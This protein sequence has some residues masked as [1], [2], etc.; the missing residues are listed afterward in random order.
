[1]TKKCK[2]VQ[3]QLDRFLRSEL[4]L[5]IRKEIEDHLTTCRKC[6]EVLAFHQALDTNLNGKAGMPDD[7]RMRTEELLAT[8]SRRRSWL[9]QAFGEPIMKKIL[10][11]STAVAAALIAGI[12]LVPSLAQGATPREKFVMMRSALAQAA[13]DGEITIS[14]TADKSGL[15]SFSVLLDGNPLPP[16]VPVNITSKE[17]ANVIDYTITIDLSGNNFSSM[18]FGK[19]QNT[20]NLVPKG[21]PGLVDV[22]HLD[23]KTGKPLN[24]STCAVKEGALQPLST[25]SYKSTSNVSTA[26]KTTSQPSDIITLHMKVSKGSGNTTVTVKNNGN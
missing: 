17:E 23:P 14:A 12:V 10:L 4:T 18:Q 5:S 21:K 8:P 19:D 20:L 6:G 13:S 26:A 16:D 25:T 2:Q 1:M 7:L 3:R 15:A 11:S 24:W 9:T 22:V